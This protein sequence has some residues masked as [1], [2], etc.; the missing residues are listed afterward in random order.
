VSKIFET[1]NKG[2]GE[3]ADLIR[4]LINAQNGAATHANGAEAGE[5]PAPVSA[6]APNGVAAGKGFSLAD[7]RVLNLQVSAPSP[8]LPF[9]EG[10]WQASEQY[11]V[12]RTKI[13]QHPKQ[14]RL[15]V[16]SSPAPGDG[17]SV[18]AINLAAALSLKSEARVLLIDGDFRKSAVHVQLGLPQ[19]PG[20]A[21]VLRGACSPEEVM[22]NTSELS[23][24]YVMCAGDQPDNPV[25]LLDSSRWP[26]LCTKLRGLFRYVII[27]SPPVAFV[28]DYDLIQAQCD[29]VILVVRPDHTYRPL[30]RRSLETIAK[31]KFL[32]VLLNC[33][34]EW[35]LGK[36]A[37]TN[38]YHYS[39]GGGQYKANGP[40]IQTR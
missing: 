32:G 23:N 30:L 3:I 19:A 8:L 6:Q 10:Q 22:V 21:E 39:K 18:S 25:E 17:K 7:C 38:Y 14:P 34:P 15:I 1:L 4:P 11:R 9:E 40:T 27:D 2:E 29:G 26:A 36:H 37:N 28:A 12:L 33:V 24:L 16:I 35:F 13:V 20:L 5:T 31:A